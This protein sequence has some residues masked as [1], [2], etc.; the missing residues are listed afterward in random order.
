MADGSAGLDFN[1]GKV[2]Q[3]HASGA[4][5]ALVDDALLRAEASRERR[6]YLGASAIGGACDREMQFELAQA[7]RE[8]GFKAYTLHK[9][10][11]GHLLEEQS[12]WW[13]C[14]AGFE[15]RQ[16]DR[17]GR[18]YRYEQ[19]AGRFKGHPDGVILKGP[20]VE[21]MGYPCLWEHK[22]VGNA[23]FSAIKREG[24][25]KHSPR[26]YAQVMIY[27]AY[28]G[29]TEHPA[30]FTVTK[31]EDG[32]QLHLLVHFDADLAQ[33]YSDRAVRVV[34]ATEAG[35]LLGRPFRDPTNFRCAACFFHQ[36]CWSLP[37]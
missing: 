9:F 7:P 13:L 16:K 28:L 2:V 34:K 32:E 36:R 30:L 37:A 33:D 5:N 10:A 8:K 27:M 6:D 25:K 26:Y 20:E 19:L 18:L 12:R 29:L 24:L 11:L 17:N 4:I 22:G 14:A 3:S 21:G 1:S 15:V 23:T 35:Q 31:A